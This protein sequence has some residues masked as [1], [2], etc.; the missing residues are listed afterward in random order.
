MRTTRRDFCVMSTAAVIGAS[1]VGV[2]TGAAMTIATS[3][4]AKLA[5]K[6]GSK[7]VEREDASLFKWPIVTEEDERAVLE[8]IRAGTMSNWDITMKFER[9]YADWMGFKHGLASCNGTASLH[10]AMFGVGMGRGDEMIMPSLTY[11][12]SGLQLLSMGATPVFA[13]IEKDSVCVDPKDI[14]RKITPRTKAVMVVHYCGHPCDMDPIVEICK[15]YKLKL[16]E[17]CSHAHGTM[18]KGRMVGTFGDVSAASLM[19]SKSLPAGEGGMLWT[20][21]RQIFERAVAFAH[22]ERTKS[23]ITDPVLKKVV[24]PD[25][26]L[27]GMPVGGI[28]GRM[29]QTCAAMGRVQLKA[30]PARIVEIQKAMNH[31]WDLLEGTPG[32]R[33]HRVGKESASTMG[34]WYNPLGHYLPEELGG[35]PVAKFIEAV[36]AEGGGSRRAANFPMHLHPV[37]TDMDVYHDG[38]P[39]RIAFSERDVRE[40]KGALPVSEALASRILGVPWF[41]HCRPEQIERYAMAYKKVALN[42][43]QLM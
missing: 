2:R 1:V 19:A 31:F 23:E 6:G 27:T 8:V 25:W 3:E 40:P 14:E 5:I 43:D 21:D 11:W 39:T 15:K 13:D 38:K 29:N 16:I 24:A 42:A 33:P 10:E 17:D 35:L 12:A 32:L 37:L 26:V 34:G 36:Q 28:K 41:K 22:Y 18:Y 30:Y 7:V 9:E 20:N 4:K